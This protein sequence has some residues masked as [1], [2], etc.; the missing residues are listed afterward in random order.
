MTGNGRVGGR[1]VGARP[2]SFATAL[3]LAVLAFPSVSGASEVPAPDGTAWISASGSEPWPLP[4]PTR[5]NGS[6]VAKVLS[7]SRGRTRLRG[8]SAR[9]PLSTRTSWSGQSQLL[10]VLGSSTYRGEKW[11]RLRLARRPSGSAA[12]FRRDRML[13]RRNPWW[14]RVRTK[15]RT[16]TVFRAGKR[17]RRFRAVV[18]APET[19][20]PRGL[21]AVYE[22][23]GQPDA[24]GF[25]GPW[26]IA[27][28]FTSNVLENYGGGPGRVAIHGRGGSSLLD[29]LGTAR[30]HGCIRISNGPVRWLARNVSRGTPVHTTG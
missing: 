25:I 12:W 22:R 21:G 29:P 9:V 23:N 26:A 27:L 24:D 20:T 4:P 17:V 8:R 3:V 2:L 13:V 11:L 30:S 19:P 6:Y 18:G 7:P 1:S 16:V 28:T 15:S 5:M 10:L 14:I